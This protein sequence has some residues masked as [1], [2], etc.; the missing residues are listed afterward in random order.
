VAEQRRKGSSEIGLE[1]RLY[2]FFIVKYHSEKECR[3]LFPPS[4]SYGQDRTGLNLAKIICLLYAASL[5]KLYDEKNN[6][7][8]TKIEAG[9]P[10]DKE[11]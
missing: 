7:I 6:E 10:N 5:H 2:Y 1:T 9:N 4:C 3:F 8:I 11:L